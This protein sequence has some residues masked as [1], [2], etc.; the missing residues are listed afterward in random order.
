MTSPSVRP[1]A[2]TFPAPPTLS[3][4]APGRRTVTA[5]GSRPEWRG[6]IALSPI[7]QH[8]DDDALFP[9]GD[10]QSDRQGGAARG[11]AEDALLAGEPAH[12]LVRLVGRRGRVLVGRG[13]VPDRGT[14]RARHVLQPVEP[15]EGRVRLHGDDPHAARTQVAPGADDRAARTGT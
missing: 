1:F 8:A 7:R 9:R 4:R 3:R 13:L 14:D 6:E 12:E 10:A 15:V 5:I 11:T 2:S